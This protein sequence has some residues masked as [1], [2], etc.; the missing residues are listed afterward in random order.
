MLVLQNVKIVP[1]NMRK[2]KEITKYDKSTVTCDISTTQCEDGTIKYDVL[3][4]WYSRLPTNGYLVPQKKKRGYS[5]IVKFDIETTQS[6]NKT[7]KFEKQIK[8]P[9]NV[10]K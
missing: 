10:T 6:D 7:I 5:R 9:L 3:V 1:S 8:E 2:N 4:T